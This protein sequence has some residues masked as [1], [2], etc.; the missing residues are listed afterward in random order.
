M[1]ASTALPAW[2]INMTRL[3]FFKSETISGSEWAPI[4]LVPF[5]SFCKKW[6]TF[7]TVLL[8]AHTYKLEKFVKYFLLR[9]Q[10]FFPI[11]TLNPWSFMFKIKFWPMTANP[12][13][14]ISALFF[15]Q[16]K[17]KIKK[18][19]DKRKKKTFTLESKTFS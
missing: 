17:L 18:P 10:Y 6:S 7:S 11:L 3:G 1:K 5:A 2:T 4:M 14:A 15:I 19:K 13:R 8:K 16:Q 12:T 9:Y